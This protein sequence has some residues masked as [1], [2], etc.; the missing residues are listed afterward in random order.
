[1]TVIAIT[2]TNIQGTSKKGQPY[3]IDQTR[4]TV[5]VP[6]D[7]EDGFGVK[8]TDYTVGS[9][10]DF[11]KYAPLRGKLPLEM[12]ITLGV[13]VNQYGQAVTVVT[14]VQLPKQG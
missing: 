11:V 14:D 7:S 5:S 6:F 1:M 9:S 4:L 13:E 12:D 3:H 2:K 8:V 10:S